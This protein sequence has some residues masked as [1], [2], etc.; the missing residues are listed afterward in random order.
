MVLS[1]ERKIFVSKE[2]SKEKSKEMPKDYLE[3]R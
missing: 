3:W 2:K 1:A